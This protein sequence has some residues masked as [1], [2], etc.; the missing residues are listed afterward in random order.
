M[1]RTVT[2]QYTSLNEV[3]NSSLSLFKRI[4]IRIKK[5]PPNLALKTE[6]SAWYLPIFSLIGPF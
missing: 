3:M 6:G 2:K 1:I 4:R 5:L